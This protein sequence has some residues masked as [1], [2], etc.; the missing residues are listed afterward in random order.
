MA[1]QLTAAQ[2]AHIA[3]L[4]RLNLTPTEIEKMAGELTSILKYVD[5]LGEVSTDGVEPTAQVT[6]LT[7]VLRND[8][9]IQNQAA[10]DDL[11]GCSPLPISEHQIQSPHAHG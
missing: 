4:A 10:P 6:G 1:T 9:V 7:N 5:M 3:R 11:L 2:V 8:V